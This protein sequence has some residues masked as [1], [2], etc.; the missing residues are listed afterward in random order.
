MQRHCTY[1]LG[2][3][4]GVAHHG[5]DAAGPLDHRTRRYHETSYS[6]SGFSWCVA[7]ALPRSH[8]EYCHRAQ[9]LLA[10]DHITARPKLHAAKQAARSGVARSSAAQ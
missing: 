4:E 7:L 1:P 6:D 8:I 9:C 5:P 3:G 2:K 10:L